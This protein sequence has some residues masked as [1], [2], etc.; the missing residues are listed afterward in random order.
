[1]PNVFSEAH[2]HSEAWM[3]SPNIVSRLPVGLCGSYLSADT[4]G[5]ASKA[6][7]V[8]RERCKISLPSSCEFDVERKQNQFPTQFLA[9]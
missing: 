9:Q 1:M 5:L 3:F 4:E 6:H 7:T 8:I 2:M